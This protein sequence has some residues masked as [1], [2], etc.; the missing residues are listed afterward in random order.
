[1]QRHSL[2]GHPL[3]GPARSQ[4][5]PWNSSRSHGS[6]G[7]LRGFLSPSKW[8]QLNQLFWKKSS[9]MILAKSLFIWTHSD[10]SGVT[11]KLKDLNKCNHAFLRTNLISYWLHS[12]IIMYTCKILTDE[13]LSN[14][15]ISLKGPTN[16]TNIFY[17]N[18][19]S[20]GHGRE[21]R[22]DALR[23]FSTKGKGDVD[24]S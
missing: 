8:H 24:C 5:R 3:S 22:G 13:K 10:G 19:S 23:T 9:Q 20:P 2:S 16:G 17:F 1:M 11:R 7:D 6:T 18:Y 14:I 15:F 21:G 12:T 4:G